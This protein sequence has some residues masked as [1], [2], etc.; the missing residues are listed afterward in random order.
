MVLDAVLA[1]VPVSCGARMRAPFAG[2]QR[3]NFRFAANTRQE[4]VVSE[5]RKIF[6]ASA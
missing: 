2:S 3:F 6:A 1:A 5:Q 4:T